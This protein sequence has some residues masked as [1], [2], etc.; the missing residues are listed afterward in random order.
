MLRSGTI[1][2]S[3]N[4]TRLSDRELRKVDTEGVELEK[5]LETWRTEEEERGDELEDNFACAI[6]FEVQA[7]EPLTA[8]LEPCGHRVHM[9]CWH[10]TKRL[11][12]Q[13][14]MK[15]KKVA[16]VQRE[17]RGL[18]VE[19]V[20]TADFV[21]CPRCQGSVNSAADLSGMGTAIE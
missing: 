3:A 21:R 18:V 17:L 4:D 19:P 15:A 10:K 7:D 8:L 13:N 12:V 5:Q 1:R 20:T 16:R 14:C 2:S 6:C 11:L 9:T